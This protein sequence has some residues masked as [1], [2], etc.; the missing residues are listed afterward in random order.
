[1]IL[2]ICYNNSMRRKILSVMSLLSLVC[3]GNNLHAIDIKNKNMELNVSSVDKNIENA[4]KFNSKSQFLDYIRENKSMTRSINED[5]KIPLKV[6]ENINNNSDNY[7]QINNYI[8]KIS[9]NLTFQHIKENEYHEIYNNIIPF[10]LEIRGNSNKYPDYKKVLRKGKVGVNTV[11]RMKS[12]VRTTI[13]EKPTNKLIEVGTKK[14]IKLKSPNKYSVKNVKKDLIKKKLKVKVLKK[15]KPKDFAEFNGVKNYNLKVT[16]FIVNDLTK[17]KENDLVK[18]QINWVKNKKSEKEKKKLLSKQKEITNLVKDYDFLTDEQKNIYI[19]TINSQTKISDLVDIDEE[20]KALKKKD[21]NNKKREKEEKAKEK[22]KEEEN[23]KQDLEDDYE[24]KEKSIESKDNDKSKN[25]KPKK[26]GSGTFGAPL[27]DMSITQDLH[28][29]LAIDYQP[30][31]CFTH[32][33]CVP[34]FAS[35]SGTAH[36]LTHS[37]YGNEVVID[38]GNGYC[39]RYAHLNSF[40]VGNGAS[41]SAGQVIGRVGTSGNSTGVHLHFEIRRGSGDCYGS[42][43]NPHSYGL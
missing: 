36:V 33:G 42:M 20:L 32:P 15:S 40:A 22:D 39:S 28:D 5:T 41:V 12:L 37:M 35:Q 23:K 18:V 2:Y 19:N 43:V 26:V 9:K 30:S 25:D 8:E 6:Q 10:A 27:S 29:G 24:S 11:T 3:L 34:A 13:S 4:R 38:H 16:K 7:N 21:D 31:G 17:L 1:M 14:Y